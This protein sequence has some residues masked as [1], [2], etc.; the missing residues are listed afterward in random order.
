VP[1]S[2]LGNPT[3]PVT[4]ASALPAVIEPYAVVFAHEQA[5]Y[6]A[7]PVER[8]P[9][10]GFAGSSWAVC[11]PTTTE[12]LEESDARIAYSDGWH[13]VASPNAA[14]GQFRFHVGSDPSHTATL[15]FDVA[16]GRIGKLIYAYATSTKGGSA[17]ILL[18]GVPR[19]ISYAGATGGMKDPVFGSTAE[20]DGLAPGRHTL[21]IKSMTG[22]VYVDRFG[23]ESST[24]SGNPPSGP[25]PT[26]TADRSL[27]AGQLSN[28]GLPVGSNATAI[29]AVAVASGN[30]PIRLVLL[31]PSGL[32]LT[33]ADS[34]GGI[35]SLTAPVSA[36]GTYTIRVINLSLG[37]IQV[38]AATTPTVS[39]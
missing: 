30:V 37:P 32:T 35:A 13:T 38:W 17:T 12:W 27:P 10:Y 34:S 6:F 28:L 3:I 18:D 4:E 31:G 9:D 22:A 5:V 19:T 29:S 33:T 7:A 14:G 24:P 39:R 11:I 23:L 8:A 21:Q 26:T 2:F 36:A 16:P 15:T 20:F 25:G 1:L